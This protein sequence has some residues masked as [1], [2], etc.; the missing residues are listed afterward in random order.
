MTHSAL[1]EDTQRKQM[2]SPVSVALMAPT[3]LSGETCQ[4]TAV[5]TTL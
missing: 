5:A 3:K 1:R 2:A 4:S